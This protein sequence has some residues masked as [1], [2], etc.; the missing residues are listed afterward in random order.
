VFAT[1]LYADNWGKTSDEGSEIPDPDE[2]IIRA[3]LQ[4]LNGE[5]KTLVMLRNEDDA[6]LV[7]GGGNDGKYVTYATFDNRSFK[8]LAKRT[9]SDELVSLNAGGQIGDYP[10]RWVVS[11]SDAMQ[12]AFRFAQ[13]G[14][15]DPSLTWEVYKG[16]GHR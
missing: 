10:S 13:D 2:K 3:A 16:S 7:I 1:S 9:E 8:I 4:H 11:L 6:N 15:L 5:T 12:A 14:I